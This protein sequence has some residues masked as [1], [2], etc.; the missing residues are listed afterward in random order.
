MAEKESNDSAI[1]EVVATPTV[2]EPRNINLKRKS[3]LGKGLSPPLKRQMSLPDLFG[4]ASQVDP[5]PDE[6]LSANQELVEKLVRLIGAPL[7]LE[8]K[9]A[10]TEIKDANSRLVQNLNKEVKS[11]RDEIHKVRD[12]HARDVSALNSKLNAKCNEIDELKS[13]MSKL[14]IRVANS[15]D[16][17]EQ[18]GRRNAVRIGNVTHDEIQDGGTDDYVIKLANDT[19]GVKLTSNDISRSH[20]SSAIR[21]G[22]CQILCKFVGYNIRKRIMKSKTKLKGSRL[23]ITEDLTRR[24]SKTLNHLLAHKRANN[25]AQVWSSDGRIMYKV[26]Q[27]DKASAANYIEDLPD[28]LRVNPPPAVF[29]PANIDNQDMLH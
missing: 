15:T 22:R 4:Q 5:I 27:G 25:I 9:N 10:V 23:Y 14:S 28:W 12:S 24:R 7:K 1:Q 8:I 17:L 3:V 18:Y 16:E 2:N 19:L 29:K 13:E 11:L 6:S 21:D 26:E 20:M